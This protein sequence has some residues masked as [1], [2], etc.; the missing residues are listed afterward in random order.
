MKKSLVALVLVL[1][2]AAFAQDSQ[3]PAAPGAQPGQ[4]PAQQKKVIKD[5]A[6]YNAYITAVNQQQPAQKAQAFEAFLQQ[7]PNSVM[8]TDAL[9]QLM[10]A[11]QGSNQPQKMEDAAKR[12]I[13]ADPTN[14]RALVVLTFYNR[15]QGTAAGMQAAGDYGQKG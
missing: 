14:L 13:Q 7:Y 5:P 4:P 6:E 3:Q 15:A 11:Y 2:T 9:E 8:K 10:A 12:V 1:A